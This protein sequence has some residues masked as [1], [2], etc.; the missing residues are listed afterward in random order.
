MKEEE[1]F[2]IISKN[3]KNN[4]KKLCEGVNCTLC[5]FLSFC[6]KHSIYFIN[7]MIRGQLPLP[8]GMGL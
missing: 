4:E 6:S 7:E 1:F 8:K 2:Y 3:I 5:D